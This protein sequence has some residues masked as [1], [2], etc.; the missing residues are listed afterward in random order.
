[1][2]IISVSDIVIKPKLANESK[3]KLTDQQILAL[4]QYNMRLSAKIDAAWTKPEQLSGVSLFAKVTFYV[5]SNGRLS[6]PRLT[7]SSGY[8]AFDQS[9]T[10]AINLANT[11]GP[12]P[13]GQGYEFSLTFRMND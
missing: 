1:M 12:T 9:I 8:T 5:S 4:S 2:P 7:K 10:S 13:T 6:N 3:V 11:A